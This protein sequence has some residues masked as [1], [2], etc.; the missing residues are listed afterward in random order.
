MKYLLICAMAL[1]SLSAFAEQRGQYLVVR[2][3][4][5][6]QDHSLNQYDDSENPPQGFQ[7]EI[8]EGY[9]LDYSATPDDGNGRKCSLRKEGRTIYIEA[10]NLETDEGGCYAFLIFSHSSRGNQKTVSYYIEQTGT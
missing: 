8:P 7:I 9:R 6:F 10:K 1:V 5:V 3:E 4:K 2:N